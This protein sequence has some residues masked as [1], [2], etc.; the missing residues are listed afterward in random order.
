MNFKMFL[1]EEEFSDCAQTTTLSCTYIRI[2]YIHTIKLTDATRMEL[3]KCNHYLILK[4]IVYPLKADH[5]QVWLI[6]KVHIAM[7][8]CQVNITHTYLRRNHYV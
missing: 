3:Y 8:F 1:M 5:N 2:Q 7:A 4:D 6:F